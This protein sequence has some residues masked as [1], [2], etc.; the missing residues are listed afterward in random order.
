MQLEVHTATGGYDSF[1]NNLIFDYKPRIIGLA[2]KARSGKDTVG[3]MLV[4]AFNAKT[5]SFAS[6]IKEALRAMLDLSE[7]HISGGLKET[8]ITW[9][10]KSPRQL[11]QTLGTEWGRQIVS[12]TLWL[13]LAAREIESNRYCGY[14][15]VVTDVRFDNEADMIRDMGGVIWHIQRENIPQ[16]SAHAS[17]SGVSL[18]SGDIIIDNNGT[19]NDLFDSVCDNF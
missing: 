6:P 2:G 19:L 3:A 10:G 14:H 8:E 15:S 17:E 13:D 4:T 1:K 16:V 11:M 5:L 7:E 18:K 12:P 9:I